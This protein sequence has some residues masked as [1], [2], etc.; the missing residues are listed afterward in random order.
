MGRRWCARRRSISRG[1]RDGAVVAQGVA[2]MRML[3]AGSYIVRAKIK[4]ASD[5]IGE[6]RRG[7]SVVGAPRAL[8]NAPAPAPSSSVVRKTAPATA[9]MRLPVAGAPR[10]TMEQVLAPE[11]LTPFLDQV[12]R[13]AGRAVARGSPASRTRA[14]VR[15]VRSRGSRCGREGVAGRRIPQRPDAAGTEQARSRGGPVPHAMRGSWISIR[16]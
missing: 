14:H 8:V 12:A 16:R 13:K 4:S 3:P 6:M 10:F 9:S 15:V 2:D 7:I 1:S 11:I 5:D